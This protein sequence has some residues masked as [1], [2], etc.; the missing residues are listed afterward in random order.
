M[1]RLDRRVLSRPEFFAVE[2]S[3]HAGPPVILSDFDL[4]LNYHP[5]AIRVSA[6]D[7]PFGAG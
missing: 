1:M 7:T 5:V 6:V 3:V 2:E 4:P